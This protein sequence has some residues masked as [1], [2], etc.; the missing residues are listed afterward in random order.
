MS[1]IEH[2][3][4]NILRVR[5]VRDDAIGIEDTALTQSFLLSP[6]RVVADWAPRGV[7]ELDSVAIDAV[8]ELKPELV[9]LG[10]GARQ[11]FPSQEVMAAFLRRQIGF[12]VM[13]N[14]AA[15]R[16]Y[17]LLAYEGRRVVVAFLLGNTPSL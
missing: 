5:W 6:D 17:H 9:L 10:T 4:E 8:L 13:D 14:A 16:T 11:R 12:E 3:S 1:L 15:A 2:T 7:D